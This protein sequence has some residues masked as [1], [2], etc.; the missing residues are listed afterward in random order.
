M[1][2]ARRPR[3]GLTDN[4]RIGGTRQTTTA[5]G[6]F[7]AKHPATRH[8]Q[9][10]H[11]AAIQLFRHVTDSPSCHGTLISH[12]KRRTPPEN[13]SRRLCAFI[14]DIRLLTCASVSF[15]HDNNLIAGLAPQFHR[16]GLGEHI[17]KQFNLVRAE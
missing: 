2:N 14:T 5:T 4:I 8:Y 16:Q 3:I 1:E 10:P 13:G 12:R 17:Q 9:Q 7:P 11:G 6:C 15:W